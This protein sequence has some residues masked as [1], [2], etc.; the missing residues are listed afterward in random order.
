MTEF[1]KLTAT[2]L[3]LASGSCTAVSRYGASDTFECPATTTFAN[4]TCN[5]LSSGY[6]PMVTLKYP[7]WY[8]YLIDLKPTSSQK[9]CI[10]YLQSS[11]LWDIHGPGG[12]ELTNVKVDSGIVSCT[13]TIRDPNARNNKKSYVFSDSNQQYSPSFKAKDNNWKYLTSD[14]VYVCS[15]TEEGGSPNCPFTE[16]D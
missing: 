2:I 6:V 13:Y 14:K 3:M 1:K 4:V 7:S 12:S 16:Y 15:Y 9:K 11:D 10:E 5:Y 8:L